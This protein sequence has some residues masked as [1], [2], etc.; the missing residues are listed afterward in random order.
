MSEPLWTIKD[1]SDY[2]Q[3]PVN[4]LYQ[5]RTRRVGPA[6]LRLG[7]HIRYRPEDVSAWVAEQGG[8]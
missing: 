7:K 3:I 8:A 6:G 1:V 4:T 2:L 5:W